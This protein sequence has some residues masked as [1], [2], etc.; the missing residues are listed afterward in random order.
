MP[1]LKQNVI[2]LA[3]DIM[4]TIECTSCGERHGAWS[5][6]VDEFELAADLDKAGWKSRGSSTKCPKCVPKR[7]AKKS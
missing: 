4:L 7:K 5:I 1:K 3:E 6:S 2:N